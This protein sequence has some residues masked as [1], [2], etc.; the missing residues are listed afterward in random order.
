MVCKIVLESI[1]LRKK[2]NLT[3]NLQKT[4]YKGYIDEK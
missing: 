2:N 1:I 3:K 4:V